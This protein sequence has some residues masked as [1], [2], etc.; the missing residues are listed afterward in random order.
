M[1]CG[2]SERA[3]SRRCVTCDNRWR[4]SYRSET[5]TT[6][7][8]KQ[9]H[10][11]HITHLPLHA[12]RLAVRCVCVSVSACAHTALTQ[13]PSAII[14]FA[15]LPEHIHARRPAHTSTSSV[16][17]TALL[18]IDTAVWLRWLRRL[19]CVCVSGAPRCWRESNPCHA[20]TY[21]HTHTPAADT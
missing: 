15:I 14:Q 19:V 17:A 3:K 12:S 10:Q 13:N 8:C 16:F 21:T 6:T 20:K 1:P 4:F 5:T 11:K 7:C 2:D 9:N 18:F